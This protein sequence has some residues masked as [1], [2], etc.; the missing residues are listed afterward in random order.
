MR[1]RQYLS[2]GKPHQAASAICRMVV[3][4]TLHYADRI[5]VTAKFNNC[6][7]LLQAH[8]RFQFST[9]KSIQ[10][11]ASRSL[12]IHT[13]TFPVSLPPILYPLLKS[14]CRGRSRK[15]KLTP[16]V[17][18]SLLSTHS[19]PPLPTLFRC[20][21]SAATRNTAPPPTREDTKTITSVGLSSKLVCT[22]L[23]NNHV[24]L[25]LWPWYLF[26]S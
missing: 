24:V 15:D 17:R 14:V 9:R 21:A 12:L 11:P 2:G 3:L 4:C 10:G 22:R 8:L 25:T 5:T 18:T 6:T 7:T 23:T 16:S 19:P 13:N 26:T 1:K 20:V